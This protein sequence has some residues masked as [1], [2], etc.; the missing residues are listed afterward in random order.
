MNSYPI[1]CRI[2]VRGRLAPHWCDWLGELRPSYR[3]NGDGEDATDLTGTLPDQSAFQSVL[4]RIWVLNL[5]LL[6][7]TTSPLEVGGNEEPSPKTAT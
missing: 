4:R 5:T 6:S 7:V 1:R 2:T 3:S